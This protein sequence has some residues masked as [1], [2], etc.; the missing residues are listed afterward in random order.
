V[1]PPWI[2]FGPSSWHRRVRRFVLVVHL[3]L[4]FFI[5]LRGYPA[6]QDG[7]AHVYGAH[8]LWAL[9]S[10]TRTPYRGFF[11]S[12]LHPAGNSLYTYIQLAL[13]ASIGAERAAGLALFA[14][15]L[16]FPAAAFAF[17]AALRRAA[18][19]G[20]LFHLPA[21]PLPW[22]ACPLAYNY[23]FYR[24]FFNYTLSLPLGML[25]LAA[26]VATGERG[27]S[28]TA[29]AVLAC[30]ACLFA[31]LASLAHPAALVFLLVAAPVSCARGSNFRRTV[32]AAVLCILVCFLFES[33]ISSGE[34]APMTF[35]SPRSA[36][37]MF[38]RAVGVSHSWLELVWAL[39]LVATVAGGARRAARHFGGLC[40]HFETLWPAALALVLSVAYFFV[41]YG[42]GGAAGLNERIPLFVVFLLL[43]YAS[44]T[45]SLSRVLLLGFVGFAVST[46]AFSS[47]RE[48]RVQVIREATAAERIP[49]GS[50]VY[51]VSLQIKLGSVSVD[52]GRHLLADI[53]RKRDFVSNGV[54][55]GHPGHVIRCEPGVPHG[56]DA[57]S[58]EDFEA[59]DREKQRS[60]LEDPRSEIRRTLEEIRNRTIGTPYLL[61][62]GAPELD[63]AFERFVLVPLGAVRLNVGVGP[64]RAYRIP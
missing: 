35:V 25:C 38:V 6:T 64:V 21:R 63:A 5:A 13:E 58:I 19:P 11:S 24:G 14:S 56:Y 30:S 47:S 17:D 12:N 41:P 50:V 20:A 10:G 42:F 15:L 57:S 59:F 22:L 62:L 36:A 29:K 60:L 55:C 40:E 48:A 34:A 53:A 9:K 18:R 43:P 51:L 32:G 27:G 26:L 28:S 45:Q 44:L 1:P 8:V 33:R 31:A 39:G 61:V 4:S 7:P 54:F 37:W 49:I 3:S 52:L 23:F 46:A 16:G 2:K